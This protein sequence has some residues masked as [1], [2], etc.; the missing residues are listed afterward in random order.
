VLM[1]GDTDRGRVAVRRH[2]S[3]ELLSRAACSTPWLC[4]RGAGLRAGESRLARRWP[5]RGILVSFQAGEPL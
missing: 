3:A 5:Q 4:A 1:L 2:R